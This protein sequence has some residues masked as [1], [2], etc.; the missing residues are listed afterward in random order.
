[1]KCETGKTMYYTHKSASQAIYSLNNNAKHP[2]KCNVC[3]AWHISSV[4]KT[5][6]IVDGVVLVKHI[7]GEGLR[8]K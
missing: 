6:E 4:I 3:D 1:M 7:D 8:V 5:I 2:Y